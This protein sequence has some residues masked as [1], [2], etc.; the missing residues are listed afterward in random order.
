M[1]AKAM[2]TSLILMI[3]YREA[4]TREICGMGCETAIGTFKL[5]NR[6]RDGELTWAA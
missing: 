2:S 1:E 3:N 5:N 4:S 6:R